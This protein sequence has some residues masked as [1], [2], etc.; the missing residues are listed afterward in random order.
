MQYESWI[1][2]Q[3]HPDQN[4]IEK[5]LCSVIA[6]WGWAPRDVFACLFLGQLRDSVQ[7]TISGLTLERFRRIVR[8][9]GYQ[10]SS[11]DLMSDNLVA[12]YRSS[13]AELPTLVM[14]P[15]LYS[16]D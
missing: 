14:S 10:D 5:K 1:A 9:A 4:A 16:V 13:S 3:Q 6:H 12:I 2:E 8:L 11:M 15:D 7:Q